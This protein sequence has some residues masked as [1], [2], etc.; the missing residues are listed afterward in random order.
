[1]VGKMAH[2]KVNEC[3]PELATLAE[4]IASVTVYD[5]TGDFQISHFG[6]DILLTKELNKDLHRAIKP[7]ADKYGIKLNYNSLRYGQKDFG[8]KLVG[9]IPITDSSE[10]VSNLKSGDQFKRKG[11]IFIVQT[12]DQEKKIVTTITNRRKRYT[13][14]FDQLLDM[15]KIQ[16]YNMGEVAFKAMVADTLGIATENVIDFANLPTGDYSAGKVIV[17]GEP[18][19]F[20]LDKKGKKVFLDEIESI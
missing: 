16:P 20:F 14:R 10:L 5:N 11:T 18:R 3:P 4:K 13:V 1:M 17:E 12:V 8:M 15:V 6:E 19:K 2:E 7:I 9:I